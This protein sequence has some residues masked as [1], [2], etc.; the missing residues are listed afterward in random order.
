MK[1]EGV[2]N[3]HALNA[4]TIAAAKAELT[5]EIVPIGD[6]RS[7]A[8]Y[9]MRVAVNLLEDFLVKIQAGAKSE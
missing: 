6:I 8:D 5:R 7:T 1:T 2:I 3:G 4:E 9:R